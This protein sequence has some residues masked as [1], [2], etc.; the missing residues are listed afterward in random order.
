MKKVLVTGGTGFVGSALLRRLV[1]QPD[2]QALAWIRRHD[3]VLPAGVVAVPSSSNRLFAAGSASERIDVVIHCAGR[4]HVLEDGAADP[5]AEYRRVNVD[6][7]LEIARQAVSRGV[8]RFVFVSTIKVNGE[9]TGEL[10]FTAQ[11]APSPAD[12]YGLSKLEAEQ[13]LLALSA[14]T[15]LEVVIVRSPLV[16]GAGVRANFLGMLHAVHRGIPLPLASIRNRRS[17]V[18]LDNLID[19][20]VV[21][22]THP[23][24]ANRVLLVSDGEAVSTPDLLRAVGRALGKPARLFPMPPAWLQA[25]AGLIGRPALFQRLCGSLALADG[26]TRRLLSWT[27]PV[28][29]DEALHLTAEY[30]LREMGR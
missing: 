23:D 17:L 15:G 19:L 16:Y 9:T 10:P 4:A 18:A 21:C 11:D 8:R 2:L 28:S 13:G 6:L 7:T 30:Y 14:Q 26:E 12:A 25:S 29:M 3:A 5:L 22:S 24:A 20:L 27:P 1:G